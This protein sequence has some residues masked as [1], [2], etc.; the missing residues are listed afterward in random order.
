M[1]AAMEIPSPGLDADALR[2]RLDAACAE[3][4]GPNVDRWL[5]FAGIRSGDVVEVAALDVPEGRGFKAI[6]TARCTSS[7]KVKR[8]LAR[9][10]KAAP[11]LYV[12]RNVPFPEIAAQ[13]GGAD[14]WL[15]AGKGDRP[16]D[17][18][19]ALCTSL[20]LDVDPVRPANLKISA[21]EGERAAAWTR[22]LDVLSTLTA[23][24]VPLDAIGIGDSGNGTALYVACAR[25]PETAELHAARITI[26]AALDALHGD[27]RVKIDSTAANAARLHPAYGTTKRK[28]A[29]TAERRHR[30][31]GFLAFGDTDAAR[32]R[33]LAEVQALAATLAARAGIDAS[34]TSTT[35]ST[36]GARKPAS[37]AS[38]KGTRSSATKPSDR[39]RAVKDA[40][41]IEEVV[42]HLGVEREGSSYLCT[43]CRRVTAS[44][45]ENGAKCFRDTC[46]ALYQSVIDYW[47]S[48]RGIEPSEA[49]VQMAEWKGIEL[50]PHVASVTPIGDDDR[51]IVRLST[52]M[53][54]ATLAAIAALAR[55]EPTLYLRTGR[56]VHAVPDAEQDEDVHTIRPL[57]L[58]R[59]ATMI[60]SR[61][62]VLEP[63]PKGDARAKPPKWLLDAIAAEDAWPGVRVLKAI[64]TIPVLRADGTLVTTPGYDAASKILYHPTVEVPEIP[65]HPSLDEAKAAA[66]VLHDVLR[67]FPWRSPADRSVALSALL[68]ILARPAIDGPVPLHMIEANVRGA[69]KSLLADVIVGIALGHEATRIPPCS[70]EDEWRKRILALLLG[71]APAI[72]ID[73][74]T[75]MLQSAALDAVLTGQRFGDR[76]LGVSEDVVVDARAVWL[77]TANNATLGGDIARRT[78][79]ARLDS[80]HEHPEERTDLSRGEGELRALV[81]E[82]RGALVAAGLTILRAWFAAGRPAPSSPIRAVGSFAAWSSVVRHALVWCGEPDPADVIPELRE[83]ADD[84]ARH[85]R[86]LLTAW[87]AVYGDEWRTAGDVL[88]DVLAALE[89]QGAPELLALA[90]QLSEWAPR[91]EALPTARVIGRRLRVVVG[92]IAGG[93]ALEAQAD[94]ARNV[95]EWRVYDTAPTSARGAITGLAGLAGSSTPLL[96]RGAPAPAPARPRP[97]A[98]ESLLQT[99]GTP[100]TPG[101]DEDDF[102]SFEPVDPTGLRW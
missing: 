83:R 3:G 84:G 14:E 56:L 5:A 52:D 62:L 66:A 81:R 87:R 70:T 93:R 67:D 26:C 91:G 54:A 24:G 23:A 16:T 35:G 100:G 4:I 89:G 90:E 76:K 36:K 64:S 49:V 8:L 71:G 69:G 12:L 97:R 78:I 7:A 73:N 17:N 32:L 40:C 65:D 60:A 88:R 46:G 72:V 27:E 15:K 20:Y 44:T 2:A 48:V 85:L 92:R 13:K 101:D 77:A 43:G 59:L 10:P 38:T 34:A 19:V 6:Y 18:Q 37:S 99:P 79:M 63:T 74:V 53:R 98:R 22:A 61:C 25:L 33:T 1:T 96:T 82:R 41:T 55:G 47:A 57:R 95:T 102:A 50:P 51:P 28:G 29:D 30:P 58:G 31:T 45:H 42:S 80:P 21:T 94:K 68:A 39:Y 11:G 86:A 9:G 75:G